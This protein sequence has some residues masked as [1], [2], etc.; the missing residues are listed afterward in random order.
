MSDEK[1]G[2]NPPKRKRKRKERENEIL[3]AELRELYN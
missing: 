3:Q 1:K 2:G